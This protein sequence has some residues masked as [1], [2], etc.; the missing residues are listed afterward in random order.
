MLLEVS[1]V[2][3]NTK[4][5]EIELYIVEQCELL[6]LEVHRISFSTKEINKTVKDGFVKFLP[7]S[8]PVLI[9]SYDLILDPSKIDCIEKV[10]FLIEDFLRDKIESYHVSVNTYITNN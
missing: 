3:Y 5:A 1:L 9:L 2:T 7:K 10:S 4:L 8:V 6:G